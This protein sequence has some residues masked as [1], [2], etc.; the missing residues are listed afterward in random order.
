MMTGFGLIGTASAQ[1]I[2]DTGPG[3][4]NRIDNKIT[5]KCTIEN[6][7]DVNVKNTNDQKATSGDATVGGSN[8]GHDG[9][10]WSGSDPLAIQ[11]DGIDG[12]G[13]GGSS[14]GFPSS[15]DGNS[16]GN[17]S[18]GF[19]GGNTFGGD[20]TTGDATN[21]NSTDLSVNID[22]STDDA[23]FPNIFSA[24]QNFFPSVRVAK[25]RVN[26]A[27]VR[28]IPGAPG[29]PG[30]GGAGGFGAGV[31][32]LGGVGVPSVARSVSPSVPSVAAVVPGRGAAVAA[33]AVPQESSIS[34]TGPNSLNKI[35]TEVNNKVTI[36]NNNDVKVTNTNNQKASTGDATVS[37]N[38]S[39]GSGDSGNAGNGND[40]G[41]GVGVS[42]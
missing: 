19:G 3:S 31:G 35:S 36:T 21:D 2:T 38:T 29:V 20:A 33:V 8:S 11:A 7:N 42:N 27:A 22:N 32:G 9:H 28:V 25:P 14:D 26:K 17:W 4:I 24:N 37:G 10:D 12:L 18:K 39:G 30:V 34:V 1:I 40:T 13:L 41:A 15:L 6:N 16:D 5:N 23:C